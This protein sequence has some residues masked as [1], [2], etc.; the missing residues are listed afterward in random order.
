M[1][2]TTKSAVFITCLALSQYASAG[3]PVIDGVSNAARIAEN[4]ATVATWAEQIAA[5]QQQYDQQMTAYTQ[6]LKDFENLN[7]ARGYGGQNRNDYEYNEGSWDET[8]GGTDYGDALD[9]NTTLSVEDAGFEAGSEAALV[10]ASAQNTNALN[11]TVNEQSYNKA[12]QRLTALNALA[13]KVNSAPDAK[14]I[15]DLQARISA[16]QMLLANEQN[17]VAVRGQLQQTQK[18]IQE[19]QGRERSIRSSALM[20]IPRTHH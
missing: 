8:L 13:D 4:I 16:E 20:P 11:Q 10:M 14:D 18:D 6:Q 5:M 2:F 17:Q 15:A 12:T 19:Q 1:D 7:G 3:I 9:E